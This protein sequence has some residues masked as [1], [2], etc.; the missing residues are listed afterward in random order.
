MTKETERIKGFKFSSF[1]KSNGTPLQA[2]SFETFTK[3]KKLYQMNNETNFDRIFY[4]EVR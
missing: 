4:N 2:M 1:E 3:W